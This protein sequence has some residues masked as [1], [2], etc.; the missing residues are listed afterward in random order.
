MDQSRGSEIAL[1][2]SILLRDLLANQHLADELTSLGLRCSSDLWVLALGELINLY[3]GFSSQLRRISQDLVE[4]G[5]SRDHGQYKTKAEFS[6]PQSTHILDSTSNVVLTGHPSDCTNIRVRLSISVSQSGAVHWEAL[7]SDHQVCQDVMAGLYDTISQ[8]DFCRRLLSRARDANIITRQWAQPSAS[9]WQD[10]WPRPTMDMFVVWLHSTT[11]D[12]RDL[13]IFTQRMGLLSGRRKTLED[14]GRQFDITRERVR[15]IARRFLRSLSHPI[16]RRQL[17]TFRSYLRTLFVK[18]DGIMTVREIRRDAHIASCLEGF[19]LEASI[20]LILHCA[21]GFRALAYDYESGRAS[22]DISYVAW[23]LPEIGPESITLTRE[24]ALSIVDN[25][26]FRHSFEELVTMVSTESGTPAATTRAS[27]RTFELI[28]EGGDGLLVR[29]G[30]SKHLSVP[31]MALIVL[32]E[33]GIPLHFREIT[34][35]VNNRFPDRSL[36]PNHVLN[37]L[38]SPIF[39]WVDRGTYGL[40]EWGLP[41]IR[42]KENYRSARRAIRQFLQDLNRPATTR[43]IETYL[44][45]LAD[46]IPGFV[47][48]SKPSIILQ[49]NSRFFISLGQG[50]WGLVEWNMVPKPRR[51]AISLACRVL[52]EDERAWLTSQRL[53]VEMKSRGWSGAFIA[54]Q[55]A[56][57]REVA[58]PIRRIQKAEL[59]GFHIHLYAL[60]SREWNEET[61]LQSLLAD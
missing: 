1:L 45:E 48:L 25:D 43:E 38:D 9:R 36:S 24:Y 19:S 29:T 21:G 56:L 46:E 28:E 18:H 30:R 52:A 22:S 54:V 53:Y 42:P 7:L 57:D 60:S 49:S 50:E 16:R 3:P 4:Q 44:H 40:A 2:D 15:Q 34:E 10:L 35:R 59:H 41:E 47:L 5:D 27:L 61:V 17:A 6:S 31:N 20:E 8:E 58:R 13:C 23:H 11:L 33:S 39:R 14:I 12:Q 26:P 55:R 51:D 37:S 32:R